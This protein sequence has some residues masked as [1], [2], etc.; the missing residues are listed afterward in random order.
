[1]TSPSPA[2]AADSFAATFNWGATQQCDD[3]NTPPLTLL[4]VPPDGKIIEIRLFVNGTNEDRGSAGDAIA[5]RTA[6]GYGELKPMGSSPYS[7]PCG[8]DHKMYR[9]EVTVK[10]RSGEVLAKA[11][12]TLPFP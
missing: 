1:M 3:K 7:G 5:G 8:P 12:G 2:P 9:L 10:N 6:F 11:T 4:N